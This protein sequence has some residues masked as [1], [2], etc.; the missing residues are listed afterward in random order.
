[1]E[2]TIINRF[3][4]FK[5]FI[6]DVVDEE[7]VQLDILT[8]MELEPQRIFLAERIRMEMPRTATLAILLIEDAASDRKIHPFCLTDF[9]HDEHPLFMRLL[10]SILDNEDSP[11]G[12]ALLFGYYGLHL[13]D[14]L[15]ENTWVWRTIHGANTLIAEEDQFV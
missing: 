10:R 6:S 4:Y 3:R 9:V 13:I 15:E 8:P 11:I 1:M 14:N 12:D 2:N 5:G 7:D